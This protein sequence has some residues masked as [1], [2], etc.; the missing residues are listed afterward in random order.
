MRM[1]ASTPV[2][3]LSPRVRGNL[4][5]VG[6]I[7]AKNGSIPACA[8][9]PGAWRPWLPSSRVY[10]RVCGGTFHADKNVHAVSGLSPRVRGNL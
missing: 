6:R 4:R 8:G 7:G 5:T 10:P 1:A 9:E 2:L 3:G